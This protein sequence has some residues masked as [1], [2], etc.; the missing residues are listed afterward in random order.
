MLNLQ[1]ETFIAEMNSSIGLLKKWVSYFEQGLPVLDVPGSEEQL[2]LL[3]RECCGEL[4]V[5]AGKVAIL[6][7]VLQGN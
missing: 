3:M 2:E 4:K 1:K 6:A 7:D 5:V